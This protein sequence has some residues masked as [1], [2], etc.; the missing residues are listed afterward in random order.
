MKEEIKNSEIKLINMVYI[1]WETY[2][3]DAIDLMLTIT[4]YFF[5]RKNK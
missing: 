5:W 4:E 3:N 2:E 1:R